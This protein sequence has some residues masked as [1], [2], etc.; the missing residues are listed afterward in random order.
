[1]RDAVGGSVVIS[2]I[3]VFIVVVSAYLAFNVNYM[4]AFKMKDK[5]I[6]VYEAYGRSCDEVNG[7]D[8]SKCFQEITNYAREIGYDVAKLNCEGAG[9]S[10]KEDLY[11]EKKVE[12]SKND[13]SSSI[14]DMGS[15]RYYKIMTKIDIRIPIVDYALDIKP[16]QINGDTKVFTTYNDKE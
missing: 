1:M 6:S 9:Y 8:K 11:C 3:M 7:E 10:S 13:E 2:I 14:V 15:S 5:V 4:K 12:V 16:F